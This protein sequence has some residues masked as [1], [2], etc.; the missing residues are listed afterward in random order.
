MGMLAPQRGLGNQATNALA[1][2]YGYKP[3]APASMI[4]GYGAGATSAAPAGQSGMR[5][6]ISGTDPLGLYSGGGTSL[7]RIADPL[8]LFGSKK[9]KPKKPAPGSPQDP[10]V[11]AQQQQAAIDAFNAEQAALPQ[12]MDVFQASPDYEFRRGEG[13]RGIENSFSARGGAQSG[14]ALRALADFNSNLASG[15]FGNFVNRQLALAGMG[16]A[17]TSQGVNA[18]QYTG[19]NVANLLGQQANARASG[20]VD[21]TNAVTGGLNDLASI[22]GNWLRNR[23]STVGKSTYGGLGLTNNGGNYYG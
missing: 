15:E 3:T 14:N 8:G 7:R 22:Y 18:A 5:D 10:A 13:M 1:R 23:Q 2:L 9:K 6:L 20:I 12:G 4:P 11:I 16:Q 19:G 17:A 21:Q